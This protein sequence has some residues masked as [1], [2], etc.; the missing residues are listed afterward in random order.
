MYESTERN[1]YVIR[2]EGVLDA[3]WSTWFAGFDISD[4]GR[5]T[6]LT[7]RVADQA[8]LYGLLARIQALELTLISVR[9][10]S[11]DASAC[12]EAVRKT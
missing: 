2:V 8:A 9:A 12:T 11:D 5:V 6:Q 3:R 4:D 10:V 1:Q 7:G